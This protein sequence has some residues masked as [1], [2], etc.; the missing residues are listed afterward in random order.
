M[1]T[2]IIQHTSKAFRWTDALKLTLNYTQLES[3]YK[4]GDLQKTLAALVFMLGCQS[5]AGCGSC[6]LHF[7]IMDYFVLVHNINNNKY[8]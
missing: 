7:N 8:K 2:H 5:K 3:F 4:L 6:A 1:L